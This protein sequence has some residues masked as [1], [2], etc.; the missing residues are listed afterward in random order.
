MARAKAPAR[1]RLL[2]AVAGAL[3]TTTQAFAQNA[4]DQGVTQHQRWELCGVSSPLD[5]PPPEL[6][7]CL[8]AAG[9]LADQ[10]FTFQLGGEIPTGLETR[11][12][13]GDGLIFHTDDPV[14]LAWATPAGSF[15][16][17]NV[18]GMGQTVLLMFLDWETRRLDRVTFS[19]QNRPLLL[20]EAIEKARRLEAWLLG[21]GFAESSLNP[22][23]ARFVFIEDYRR[24]PSGA[25]SWAE[26]EFQLK[27]DEQALEMNLFS[28][29][30]PDAEVDVAVSNGRR[31]TWAFG[32]DSARLLPP[33]TPRSIYDG[34]GG[35]EWQLEITIARPSNPDR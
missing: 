8:A 26:A 24:K 33:G 10:T 9:P 32:A 7:A 28:L 31:K 20:T 25:V 21:S 5:P 3:V 30:A 19:W 12:P 15:L 17:D 18:G 27:A 23:E 16:F 4:A 14:S 29:V 22:A 13:V 6:V 11:S 35:Y 1:S 34:N 2:L